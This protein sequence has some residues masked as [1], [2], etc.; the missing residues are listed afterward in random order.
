MT[1]QEFLTGKTITSIETTDSLI[2]NLVI[3]ES[4]Y[5]I[6]VDTSNLLTGTLL[7]RRE[8]FEIENNILICG[9]MSIDMST[10]NML[11]KN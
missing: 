11:S 1:V 9:N 2:I 8:D 5:G 7:Y 3:G 4:I 6:D 10:T